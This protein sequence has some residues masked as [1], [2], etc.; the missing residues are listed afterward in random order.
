MNK[1]ATS[2]EAAREGDLEQVKALLKDNPDLVFCKDSYG[3]SPLHWA[4]SSGR[5]NVAEFLLAN[6]AQID[7]RDNI[8]QTPLHLAA[9]GLWYTRVWP[10]CC[11]PSGQT[12]ISGATEPVRL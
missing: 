3:M 4:A 7:S 2:Y 12:S 9:T 5:K 11:W 10:N 8:G 6:K 1:T